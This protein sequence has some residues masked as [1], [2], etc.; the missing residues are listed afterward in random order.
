[1]GYY[2]YDKDDGHVE[3]VSGSGGRTVLG[4]M[5]GIVAVLVRLLGMGLI[6]VGLGIGVS[7]VLEAWAL[8]KAP[9]RIERFAVAIEQGSN[10]DSAF[11][12][13]ARQA[14]S[15]A[16][17]QQEPAEADS[18]SSAGADGATGAASKAASP[19]AAMASARSGGFR[20]SYFAA[21]A[22]VL[23]LMLVV[24]MLAMSA[25]STGARLALAYGRAN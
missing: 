10:I 14:A 3:E 15:E 11:S 13:L 24:G 5:Q 23:A 19:A 4:V 25:A 9:E 16:T 2:D 18:A 1:M 7:V 6:L 8:Y 20:L 12:S 17:G 22:I 21:W